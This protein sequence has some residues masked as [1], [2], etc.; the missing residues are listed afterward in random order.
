MAKATQEKPTQPTDQAE[1]ICSLARELFIK[2][3]VPGAPQQRESHHVAESCFEL[4]ATFYAVAAT[5]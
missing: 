2:A 5:K 3:S 4:A 1:A